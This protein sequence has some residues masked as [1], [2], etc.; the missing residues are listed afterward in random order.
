LLQDS[1]KFSNKVDIWAFGCILYYVATEGTRAFRDGNSILEYVKDPSQIRE[2]ELQTEFWN[3]HVNEVLRECLHRDVG[4]R[5][6]ASTLCDLLSLYALLSTF[7]DCLAHLTKDIIGYNDLKKIAKENVYAAEALKDF[8]DLCEHH[9]ESRAISK[10]LISFTTFAFAIQPMRGWDLLL[11]PARPGGDIEELSM[12]LRKVWWELADMQ[13]R[14]TS[15][16]SKQDIFFLSILVCCPHRGSGYPGPAQAVRISK[17]LFEIRAE[18]TDFSRVEC[19][20]RPFLQLRAFKESRSVCM[21]RFRPSIVRTVTLA[22]L[23]A[24]DGEYSSAMKTQLE[25]LPTIDDPFD[26]PF[27]AG[28]M[29]WPVPNIDTRISGKAFRANIEKSTFL[30]H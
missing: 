9:R 4:Q 5:P 19:F 29:R 1:P 30:I 18:A 6:G 14:I 25:Y 22:T 3:A 24:M 21:E 17:E 20:C 26:T 8:M 12:S 13:R 7:P 15:H 27:R 2:V 11:R 10:F 23:Y 16:E 28:K